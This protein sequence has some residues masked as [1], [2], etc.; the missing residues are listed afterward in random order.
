MNQFKFK[1][2]Y[3]EKTK[4]RVLD[5]NFNDFKTNIYNQFEIPNEDLMLFHIPKELNIKIDQFYDNDTYNKFYDEIIKIDD[6]NLK[7]YF[8]INLEKV[9]ELPKETLEKTK[10]SQNEINNSTMNQFKFKF[11]YQE[12][13]KQR[14]LDDN[15]NDFKTNIYN[16]FEI[17]N[18]DL[19]L[20][21]IPKELNIKI[22]NFYDEE[23]YNKFYE[24]I[25]KIEDKNLKKYF[26]INL[27]KVSQPISTSNLNPPS[28]DIK[29]DE[30]INY[31]F[32]NVENVSNE[33]TN[34]QLDEEKK[35][36]ESKKI[37]EVVND[38]EHKNIVCSNCYKINFKGLRFICSECQNFN[39]CQECE[40]LK[41]K[42]LIRHNQNHI[43]IR[44]NKPIDINIKKYDNI[45]KRNNQN[46]IVDLNNK[47]N[48]LI[49]PIT[50]INNGEKSF[51]NCYFRPIGFGQ[52]YIDGK[53]FTIKDNIQRTEE[54]EIK[55]QLKEILKPGEYNSNWRMFTEKGIP[56]GKVLYLTIY[57]H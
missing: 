49:I 34:N 14:V 36:F 25:I 24:K 57:A 45:I 16:Q 29:I 6:K 5:N 27:E 51:K 50:I 22:D 41:I 56:F 23:T 26:K 42:K 8:K 2:T 54:I 40:D 31:H 7:K 38:D 17:P 33:I 3:Q 46:L 19:I 39:L 35:K 52:N 21:H 11:I 44:I 47:E 1:I 18:E 55:I 53:K 28:L 37:E 4:Q 32:N 10:S 15:F 43:F 48:N 20:F 30:L 9:S 13:T 12:K